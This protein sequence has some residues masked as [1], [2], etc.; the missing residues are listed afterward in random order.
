MPKKD[1]KWKGFVNIRVGLQP[2]YRQGRLKV[3]AIP[4]SFSSRWFNVRYIRERVISLPEESTLRARLQ[5]YRND[6]QVWRRRGTSL[7]RVSSPAQDPALGAEAQ[8]NPFVSARDLTGLAGKKNHTYFET[9]E[10]SLRARHAAVKE[11]LT[12][13]HKLDRLRLLRAM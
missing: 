9:K 1:G 3:Q 7:W 10:T 13:E 8:R 11:L 12:D 2:T 4:S 5:K 6:G